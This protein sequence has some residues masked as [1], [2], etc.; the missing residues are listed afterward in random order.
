[1]FPDAIDPLVTTPEAISPKNSPEALILAIT[2]FALFCHSVR[3][4]V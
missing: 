2:L 4:A 1:M 3:F